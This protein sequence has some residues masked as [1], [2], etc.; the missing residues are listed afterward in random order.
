MIEVSNVINPEFIDAIECREQPYFIKFTQFPGF[1]VKVNPKGRISFITYGRVH[2][3]GNPRT[4]THGTTKDLTIDN[5]LDKHFHCLQLLQKG[6][7]PNLI[8]KSKSK[9]FTVSMSFL[10]VAEDFIKDKMA[11]KEYDHTDHMIV[12]S[13]LLVLYK[14][15]NETQSKIDVAEKLKIFPFLD[16]D[17]EDFL[18]KL[19]APLDDEHNHQ[20]K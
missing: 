17:L 16:I 15:K 11:K 19:S 20:L 18:L 7:D 3:G 9:Q 8:K 12:M 6:L 5:A 13:E 14:L 10:N 4:I 2:F 1:R